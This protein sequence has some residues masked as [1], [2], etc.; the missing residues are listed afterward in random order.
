[1][2]FRAQ[3]STQF[4]HLLRLRSRST[5]PAQM[6]S[7][8][9][10]RH[11]ARPAQ[12][13]ETAYS[14]SIPPLPQGELGLHGPH[15]IRRQPSTTVTLSTK[16]LGLLT[17]ARLIATACSPTAPLFKRRPYLR[18]VPSLPPQRL[19]GIRSTTISI[20]VTLVVGAITSA[21]PRHAP[22]VHG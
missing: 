3:S 21:S 4:R 12:H 17:V 15:G 6:S 7:P 13:R 20:A 8:H 2:I 18:Y 22:R 5:F 14:G 11:P 16:A 9:L 10:R 19:Y 1:M